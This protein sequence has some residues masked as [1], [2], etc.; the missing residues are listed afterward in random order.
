MPTRTSDTET[1]TVASLN[2]LLLELVRQSA[3]TGLQVDSA[4][5]E[6]VA[7]HATPLKR[8]EQSGVN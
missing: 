6:P 4:G 2:P 3:I 8:S 5:V 7:S 1:L